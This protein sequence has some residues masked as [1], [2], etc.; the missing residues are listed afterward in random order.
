[1]PWVAIE[2]MAPC[3]PSCAMEPSAPIDTAGS[4]TDTS[5]SHA[6]RAMAR[7]QR[8]ARNRRME[9]G[10]DIGGK[11]IPVELFHSTGYFA[12]VA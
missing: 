9:N 12:T 3:M 7:R 8:E 1:M 6:N 11:L 2:V 5:I 4:D 10:E